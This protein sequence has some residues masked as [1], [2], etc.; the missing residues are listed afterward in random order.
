[1]SRHTTLTNSERNEMWAKSFIKRLKNLAKTENEMIEVVLGD[2][3]RH[4]KTYVVLKD[5]LDSMLDYSRHLSINSIVKPITG[6][7]IVNF[8]IYFADFIQNKPFKNDQ[9][10][11]YRMFL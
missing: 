7:R 5:N 4:P 9:E 10:R 2:L 8:L 11:G 3:V 6:A 1:M